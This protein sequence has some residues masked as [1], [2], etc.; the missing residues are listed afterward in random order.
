M[1]VEHAEEPAGVG[2]GHAVTDGRIQ[3]LVSTIQLGVNHTRG[4]EGVL[5][6][7]EGLA[8]GQ[9]VGRQNEGVALLLAAAAGRGQID[10][11][12][13]G[14][15]RNLAGQAGVGSHRQGLGID[16][17]DRVAAEVEPLAGWVQGELAG[18]TQGLE[19]GA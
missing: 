3:K 2:A 9:A 10:P 1:Q 7:K 15:G 11:I 12:A 18:V 17:P 19:G 16:R 5:R 13:A 6:W 8:A 4:R 14:V